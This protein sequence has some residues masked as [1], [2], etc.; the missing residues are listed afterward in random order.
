MKKTDIPTIAYQYLANKKSYLLGLR[1]RRVKGMIIGGGF[2]SFLI[3]GQTP[4][5]GSLLVV[6][7]LI[8]W[9]MIGAYID[10]KQREK[11]KNY[12]EAQRAWFKI[13]GVS[14]RDT[15]G[16]ALQIFREKKGK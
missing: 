3:G 7:W 4:L 5:G 10:S 14:I 6:I 15:N 13:K 1:V 11:S 9:L 16:G 12:I 8:A 2:G